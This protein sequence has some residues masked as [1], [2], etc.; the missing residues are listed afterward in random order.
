MLLFRRH[1]VFTFIEC[2]PELEG[3]SRNRSKSK[4]RAEQDR[5][6][7]FRVGG[8]D[9]YIYLSISIYLLSRYQL[10]D[11][12][13]YLCYCLHKGGGTLLGNMNFIPD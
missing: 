1:A 5:P 7:L 2:L 12:P 9:L 4:D 8:P 13:F 3:L 6:S 10:T 11:L